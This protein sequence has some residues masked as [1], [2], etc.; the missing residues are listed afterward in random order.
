[1]PA[2]G[3]SPGAGGLWAPNTHDILWDHSAEGPGVSPGKLSSGTLS[4]ATTPV[5]QTGS[6]K[7]LCTGGTRRGLGRA[8]TGTP[9]T[10]RCSGA[11]QTLAQDLPGPQ[12]GGCPESL[13]QR[14]PM[15]VGR[16]S[17]DSPARR[18]RTCAVTN[19][20]RMKQD[21]T[22]YPCLDLLLA[23]ERGLCGGR[24]PARGRCSRGSDA[25]ASTIPQGSCP[26]RALWG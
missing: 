10:G 22:K 9:H 2:M 16:L 17:L 14:A 25:R 15:P 6:S 23:N 13:E 7:G 26:Q 4:M 8:R 20:P 24:E 1:M 5:L 18:P 3:R 19:L 21:K 12:G 11:L